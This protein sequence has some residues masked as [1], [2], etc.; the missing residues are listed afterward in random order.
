MVTVVLR[1]T[2]TDA[3]G[4]TMVTTGLVVSAVEGGR[5]VAVGLG[6]DVGVGGGVCVGVRRGTDVDAI[7]VGVGD[8]VG[9]GDTV[10]V[11]CGVAII[12]GVGVGVWVPVG[13]GRGVISK[14]GT[15][16][17]SVISGSAGGIS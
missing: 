1:V 17:K 2:P 15:S 3:R 11:T 6:V 12:V 14:S 7:L 4:E 16:C 13:V 9:V 5:G 8:G 10:G